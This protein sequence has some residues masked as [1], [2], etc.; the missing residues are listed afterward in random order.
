MHRLDLTM[1]GREP[2]QRTDPQERLVV[3]DRPK[4]DVGRLQ[5]VEVQGVCATRSRLRPGAGQ[6]DVK[7]LDHARVAEVALD[8]SHHTA[9]PLPKFKLTHQGSEALYSWSKIDQARNLSI[10]IER[11]ISNWTEI[12]R[13]LG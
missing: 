6:M 12:D 8:D 7:K 11:A 9:V 1:I 3:P 10:R 13:R 2:L 4:A 5:P